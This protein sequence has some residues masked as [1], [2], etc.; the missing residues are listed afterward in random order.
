MHYDRRDGKYGRQ[1]LVL[2][3]HVKLLGGTDIDQQHYFALH[4]LSQSIMSA[5]AAIVCS[6]ILSHKPITTRSKN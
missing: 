2:A 1:A 5:P 6:K 4:M 3:A